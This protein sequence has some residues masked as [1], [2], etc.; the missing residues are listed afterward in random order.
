MSLL[1]E[2][3]N[4]PSAA[5]Q[6]M[7]MAP[8]LGGRPTGVSDFPRGPSVNPGGSSDWERQA[9]RYFTQHEGYSRPEWNAVDSII[10]RESGWDPNAVNDSSGAAG[11][12]QRIS[13]YGQGYRQDNPMQQIKWLANY[14]DE[15]YGGAI[16]ALAFKDENGW[17]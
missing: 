9:R 16:N 12:A 6:Y 7:S 4:G 15:R 2:L 3:L 10:E 11:I 1:E 8:A 13:G 5:D 17:Y 14:L